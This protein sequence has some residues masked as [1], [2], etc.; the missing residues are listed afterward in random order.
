VLNKNK[1]T[2][3]MK[4]TVP[5]RGKVGVSTAK[6]LSYTTIFFDGPGT[7]KLPIRA[8]QGKPVKQLRAT[9]K[10]RAKFTV[11]YAPQGPNQP[12]RGAERRGPD[13]HPE[14]GSLSA[15]ISGARSRA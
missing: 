4:V 15:A 7:A 9:G 3:T 10:L 2:A 5:A 12:P 6:K 8:R 11:T 13:D 1:G 14:T